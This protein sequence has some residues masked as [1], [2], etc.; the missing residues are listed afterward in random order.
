MFRLPLLWLLELL[1][2]LESLLGLL[3]LSL[4]GL[5]CWLLGLELG[6][7]CVELE[8][9]VGWV[10]GVDERICLRLLDLLLLL[11]L[12]LLLLGLELEAGGWQLLASGLLSC[13][14]RSPS[15]C[16]SPRRCRSPSRSWS[17]SSS[18][19]LSNRAPSPPYRA[20]PG[21]RNFLGF[22]RKA[23]L[24][25]NLGVEGSRCEA[26][27][28]NGNVVALQDPESVLARR[29]LHCDRLAV[30]V[31]VAVL[32]DPLPVSGHLLPRDG[33]VLLSVRRTEP[34]ISCIEPLL[35]QDLCIL[36]VLEL[37]TCSEGQTRHDH[38]K[39]ENIEC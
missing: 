21:G 28:T 36:A 18:R 13:W 6:S 39:I 9:L 29:V 34:P 32:A 14:S 23:S 37:G 33:S 26:S 1:L 38:L 2:R 15:R 24:L 7:I 10:S 11:R 30:V 5:P 8:V 19:T 22:W 20:R 31:D 4:L 12:E 17:L 3:E 35:L 27:G 16:R 25:G